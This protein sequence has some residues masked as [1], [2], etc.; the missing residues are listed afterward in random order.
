MKRL[1]IL[2]IL[3]TALFGFWA[4]TAATAALTPGETYT[5]EIY[6]ITSS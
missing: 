2:L 6:P 3:G 5:V 4:V 1:G